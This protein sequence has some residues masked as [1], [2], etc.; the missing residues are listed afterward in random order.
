MMFSWGWIMPALLQYDLICCTTVCYVSVWKWKT[1]FLQEE[2]LLSSWQT[3]HNHRGIQGTWC[4][5]PGSISNTQNPLC[6]GCFIT[7]VYFCSMYCLICYLSIASLGKLD[8]FLKAP[9]FMYSM[10]VMLFPSLFKNGLFW[11]QQAFG[12]YY[13]IR[14]SWKLIVN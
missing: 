7:N 9:I 14:S 8:D 10:W 13:R 1:V 3:L 2:A 11:L 6:L 12:E 4:C 5:K